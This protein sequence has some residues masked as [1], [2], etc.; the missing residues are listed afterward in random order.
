MPDRLS[1]QRVSHG[2]L[3]ICRARASDEARRKRRQT[4]RKRSPEPLVGSFP[5]QWKKLRCRRAKA[6]RAKRRYSQTASHASLRSR[7]A[8]AVW[9]NWRLNERANAQRSS[10]PLA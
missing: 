3:L 9:P 4:L 8:V 1:E 5:K 6:E 2:I 10:K 7:T